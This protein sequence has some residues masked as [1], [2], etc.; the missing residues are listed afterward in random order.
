MARR[1]WQPFAAYVVI[2][3]I[4]ACGG[5]T[6]D[7]RRTAF[8][9]G[10]GTSVRTG[11]FDTD[12]PWS[13]GDSQLQAV[14][15]PSFTGESLVAALKSAIADPKKPDASFSFVNPIESFFTDFPSRALCMTLDVTAP[16]SA[17]DAL[18]KQLRLNANVTSI[19]AR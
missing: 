14:F 5:S 11:G 4:A 9:P 15:G 1:L 19:R 16:S 10:A 12:A 7:V 18:V 17:T 6:S 13:C 3:A 8:E 2:S